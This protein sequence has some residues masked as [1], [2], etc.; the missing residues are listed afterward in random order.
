MALPSVEPGLHQAENVVET[1]LPIR[2][3]APAR[4]AAHEGL[5]YPHPTHHSVLGL[6]LHRVQD[7][8]IAKI[9]TPQPVR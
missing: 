8:R 5:L 3:I 9:R 2:S 6:D 4:L 7:G 1:T